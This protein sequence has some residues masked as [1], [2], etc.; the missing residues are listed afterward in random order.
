[1]VTTGYPSSRQGI[2]ME[3]E[4]SLSDFPPVFCAV[5]FLHSL[6]EKYMF[7]NFG[8]AAISRNHTADTSSNIHYRKKLFPWLADVFLDIASK[9]SKHDVTK[10]ITGGS[11]KCH[12][13]NFLINVTFK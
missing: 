1:M 7:N 9:T 12:E 13:K 8:K 11:G 10:E 3:A 6:Q 2:E 4:M 5:H